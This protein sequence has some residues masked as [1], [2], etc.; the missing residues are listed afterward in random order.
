[1]LFPSWVSF[2]IALI[3]IMALS[4]T[5]LAYSLS[6]GA[7]VFALLVEV[8]LGESLAI[9]LLDIN[10]LLLAAIVFII[11]LLGGVMNESNMMKELIDN[12]GI[13]KKS[14]MM[15]S[16]ALYGLLPVAGGA[17]LSMPMVDQI[18]PDPTF[19]KGQKV[20]INVW[21]RHIFILVYP[22][23]STLLI[24]SQL[25]GLSLY[26]EV[27]ILMIP[28]TIMLITG[29]VFLIRPVT[30]S[31]SLHARNLKIVL[32]HLIPLLIAPIFDL[33]GRSF[34]GG[35]YPDLY[36]LLGLVVSL[37]VAMIFGKKSMRNVLTIGK[38]MQVWKFPLLIL[39]I[40]WFQT[41][42][43][44]SSV[45]TEISALAISF[46]LFLGVGFFLGF[47]TGRA[48]LPCTILIPV[49]LLQYG[50]TT[51]GLIP[52]ALLYFAI[53]L[54]YIITPIHP[55]VSYSIKAMNS[56]YKDA[57]R[58]FTM[59]TLVSALITLIFALFFVGI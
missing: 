17:I 16:P 20:A 9:V 10:Y 45:P 35:V 26:A 4:K 56:T 43:V 3:I 55:C 48:A 13:S 38:K 47:A 57:M 54:G 58:Y 34:F 27:A 37:G 46:P 29:Y 39:A 22:L 15:L 41:V 32:H 5:E 44:M 8:P 52:F 33:I 24:C 2:I 49:Y 6:L 19:P 42:F 53:F 30:N 31:K 14:G 7:L 40:F 50:T 28:F 23:A 51:M 18:E 36:L 1:M 25:T 21:Y 11:P 59:P 12:L